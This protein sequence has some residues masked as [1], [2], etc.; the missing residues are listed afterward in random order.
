MVWPL[1][2]GGVLGGG[3]LYEVGKDLGLWGKPTVVPPPGV[4]PDGHPVMTGDSVI[5]MNSMIRWHGFKLVDQPLYVS[6]QKALGVKADGWP[7]PIT[8]GALGKALQ[9]KG[10]AQQDVYAGTIWS[11]AN[12]PGFDGIHSPTVA[13]WTAGMPAAHPATTAP[14]TGG[15]PAAGS[16]VANSGLVSGGFTGPGGMVSMAAQMVDTGILGAIDSTVKGAEGA[17]GL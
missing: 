1:L 12:P 13:E 11:F 14:P 8:M 15:M 3:A 4:T 16:S 9:A 5:D 6:A 7:G 2:I 17:A 10:V